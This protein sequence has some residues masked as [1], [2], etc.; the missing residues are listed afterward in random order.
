MTCAVNGVC[1]DE[2]SACDNSDACKTFAQCIGSCSDQACYD[3][4]ASQTPDGASVFEAYV[5]CIFVD[6]C[7]ND[8]GQ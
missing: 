7:P 1:S 4:C 6:T 8:C 5:N 2:F 3:G